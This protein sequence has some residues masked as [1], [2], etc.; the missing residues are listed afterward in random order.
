MNLEQ[1]WL[2]ILSY[3]GYLDLQYLPAPS[4]CAQ[5]S[6]HPISGKERRSHGGGSLRVFEQFVWL[7]VD[8]GK[9]ALSHPAHQRVTQTVRRFQI[10]RIFGASTER[11]SVSKF[12][13]KSG[14]EGWEVVGIC[15]ASES[16]G[17]WRFRMKRSIL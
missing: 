3:V 13:E 9:V 5:H 6:V 10:S 12:L 4:K 15:P 8:S 14:Q 11:P 7:G 16:A 2:S 17:H 1:E